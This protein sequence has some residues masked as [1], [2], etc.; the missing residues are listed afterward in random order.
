MFPVTKDSSVFLKDFQKDLK[1]LSEFD[2]QFLKT[3]LKKT[4]SQ[5]KVP[6]IKKLKNYPHAMYRLR[7]GSFRLLF[8]VDK[9][10]KKYIFIAV[11]HRKNLY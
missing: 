4:F 11:K 3:Q 2:Q 8:N 7:I 9:E 1:K 5:K 6:N 10:K